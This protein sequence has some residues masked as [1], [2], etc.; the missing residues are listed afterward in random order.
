MKMALWARQVSRWCCWLKGAHGTEFPQRL[1]SRS[2]T[3][4]TY[5]AFCPL[6]L[7][8]SRN[9]FL[10]WKLQTYRPL[11]VG[12]CSQPASTKDGSL[13]S[14]DSN[15]SSQV[16]QK[17]EKAETLS[18]LN[19]KILY[20]DWDD[21]PP[22]S[23]LEEISEEEAMRIIA[24]PLLPLKSSTLR[25]YVDH[26][27]TLAKLV[28]LGVDLSQ[29]EKH[30]KA[31]QLLLTLDFEKDIR[32]ILLFLKDVGVED[33]QLGSFLTKNPYILGED[34]E[35]LET[36]VAYLKSKK[37]GKA[38]IAQMVSRAPYLLLFSVERL[39]NRL[40]FF[41]NE[42]GLSVRKTK[43]LV[44]RLPRLLTGKL[45]PVKENIQVCQIELG[46]QRNE[47]QHIVFKT[48]KI[49]TASKK[50]LRQTFDYL[51]NVM[52]I[53]HDMLT[54]FPQVFNSKL[55][56]IKERHLFLMFLGRAQYDPAQPSYISL[57]QLVS[58]PDEV[59]CTEIAKASIQDFEKF[60]KTL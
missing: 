48:P 28:H 5:H 13:A 58:L 14:P 39:D 47:I 41:K 36:R 11:S 9:D 22:S 19:A 17:Q 24:E 49:L 51:H 25:D 29:V 38:E 4:R 42:L 23:A 33:N 30:Q 44:I 59:F 2:N 8:P 20:E 18:D 37:F 27:E 56:R 60:L 31:G 34:L 55:L 21:I 43:D 54:Q 1:R 53:P 40:G 3:T 6:A 46:F 7:P 16:N 45:E 26:S 57:D 15:L 35:A 52:G 10:L 12:S 50:R 32:K